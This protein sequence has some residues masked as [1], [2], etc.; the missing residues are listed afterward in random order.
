[1]V[2]E[3]SSKHI[4]KYKKQSKITQKITN[5]GGYLAIVYNKKTIFS[6]IILH[7]GSHYKCW[8]FPPIQKCI[9]GNFVCQK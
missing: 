9:V 8:F 7:M 2:I 5:P 3:K 4:E 6:D 1:M